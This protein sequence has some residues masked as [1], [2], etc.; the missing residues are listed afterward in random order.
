MMPQPRP[1][2]TPP[3][4]P[5]AEPPPT[6]T[7]ASGVGTGV[8]AI[9]GGAAGATAGAAGGPVAAAAGALVGAVAGAM[10]GNAATAGPGVDPAA[11]DAYWRQQ[12]RPP[13]GASAPRAYEDFAAAYRAGYLGY[14][15]D[16]GFDEREADL[17]RAYEETTAVGEALIPGTMQ[18]AMSTRPLQWDEARGPARAAYNRIAARRQAERVA[19]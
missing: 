8:G 10:A 6:T 3:A 7:I 14:R 5:P 19:G 15:D 13:A 9:A 1:L 11:E 2:Q 12:H 17:R 18:H 16:L 4:E